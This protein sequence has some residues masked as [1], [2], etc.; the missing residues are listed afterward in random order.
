[1]E[2]RVWLPGTASAAY[3][4]PAFW[5][6]GTPL[7]WPTSGE[8]DVMEGLSGTLCWHYHY[9]GGGPGHCPTVSNKSGW[10]TFGA[11][12]EPG[13]IDFYYDGVK[14]SQSQTAGVVANSMFLILNNGISSSYTVTVPSAMQVD[15]V[16]VW[17]K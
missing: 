3:D 13:R 15:Y 6:D 12:W 2:A 8:I 14:D 9:S 17:Q 11:D 10:H 1:M 7:N 4:W 5:A 16:R